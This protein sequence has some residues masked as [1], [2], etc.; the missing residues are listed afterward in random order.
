[1]APKIE[2]ELAAFLGDV[3]ELKALAGKLCETWDQLQAKAKGMAPHY[4]PGA[5][6]F[7]AV[8]RL[9]HEVGELLDGLA[10]DML[11]EHGDG[12]DVVGTVLE[13][14]QD[15]LDVLEIAKSPRV[16]AA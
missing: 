14:M 3:N 15:L 7:M 8:P 6:G 16:V 2:P 11:D 5:A 12:R 1:M 13:N 9:Y 4:S 10:M